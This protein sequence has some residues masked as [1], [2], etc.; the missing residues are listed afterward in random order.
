MINLI[1]DQ[2]N[3]FFLGILVLKRDTGV[4]HLLFVVVSLVLMSPFINL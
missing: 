1:L 4:I 2:L 3:M